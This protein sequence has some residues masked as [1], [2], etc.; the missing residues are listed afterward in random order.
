MVF[1]V[2]H[3]KYEVFL[4]PLPVALLSHRAKINLTSYLENIFR[5]INQYI[6]VIFYCNG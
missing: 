3:H 5:V 2:V 4:E 6:F 1:F